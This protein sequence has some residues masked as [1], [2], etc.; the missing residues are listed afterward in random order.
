[1]IKDIMSVFRVT[2]QMLGTRGPNG[3]SHKNRQF[4]S[5]Q[6]RDLRPSVRVEKEVMRSHTY[7]TAITRLGMIKITY[8]NSG[9]HHRLSQLALVFI[10]HRSSVLLPVL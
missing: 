4:W 7:P 3:D 2:C 1:M 5:V 8:A 9:R 10:A 6:P